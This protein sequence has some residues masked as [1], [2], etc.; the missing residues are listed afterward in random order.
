MIAM[1]YAGLDKTPRVQIPPDV[2]VR[3]LLVPGVA[4]GVCIDR[5]GVADGVEVAC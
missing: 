2:G 5:R 4:V 1:P 3:Q